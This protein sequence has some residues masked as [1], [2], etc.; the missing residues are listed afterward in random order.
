MASA[1]DD[2]LACC[3]E[4]TRDLAKATAAGSE[5]DRSC[6][7]PLSALFPGEWDRVVRR[8]R[9]THARFLAHASATL[10]TAMPTV[11]EQRMVRAP[12]SGR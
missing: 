7:L 12:E 5:P 11:V 8:T 9:E 2:A 10:G 3:W 1:T 6:G 4:H